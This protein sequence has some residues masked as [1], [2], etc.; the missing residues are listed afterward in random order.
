MLIVI[1]VTIRRVQPIGSNALQLRIEAIE[2][3]QLGQDYGALR[4]GRCV[5]H[6]G[7]N[8]RAT[9]PRQCLANGF[10]TTCPVGTEDR[11]VEA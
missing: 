3:E 9:E 2:G 11:N 10:V 4:V 1:G 7:R 6:V 5:Q 8:A